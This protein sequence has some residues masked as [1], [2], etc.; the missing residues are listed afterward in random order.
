MSIGTYARVS[1][2]R[3][4]AIRVSLRPRI[5]YSTK[6]VPGASRGI[7]A[8]ASPN[9]NR[10]NIATISFYE[11]TPLEMQLQSLLLEAPSL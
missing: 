7:M 2:S 6:T 11:P 4:V 8:P 1:A 5:F 10:N 3:W 9:S